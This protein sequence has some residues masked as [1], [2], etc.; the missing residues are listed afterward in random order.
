MA[1]TTDDFDYH[2]PAERVAQAALAE[3]DQSRLMVLDR[4]SGDLGHHVFAELPALLR[5]G[6]V[7][8]LNDTRVIPARFFA[9]RETGGRIEGLFLRADED[10]CWRVMLKGAARCKAG[11][12]L[13]AGDDLQLELVENLGQGRW[14]LRAETAESA[15]AVL[16]RIGQTPLPPYIRRPDDSQ[17]QADRPRY[18][19]VYAR[20]PGA[21][22]AP[23]AGLH[24]TPE[25]F[26]TLDQR[27][28]ERITVTLHVGLG[29]FL[30]VKADALDAHDMHAEWY[31]LSAEAAVR[32]NVARAAGRRIVAVGT[33]SVRVLETVARDVSGEGELFRAA[34]GCTDIFLY[35]PAEFRATDALVT[36]FHLPKSTLLMLVA[37]FCEPGGTDG[38][39]MILAAY[40]EAVAREYRFYSYGD[41]MLIE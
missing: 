31:D 5:A 21:V 23:T 34:N 18:Q 9:R 12:R 24:F 14:V 35:P 36:N 13:T 2:L 29:T 26:D 39:P 37:A 4:A 8:V 27:D 17:E 19:T 38:L 20:Q 15:V 40:A 33:T 25:V 3:R 22:A 28:I 30:P 16:D 6:D 11:Q 1:L 7:L 10:G 41:A 32:L